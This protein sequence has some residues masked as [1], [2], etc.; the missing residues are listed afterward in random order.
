[1]KCQI[2]ISGKIKKNISKCRML[3]IL[4]R[5]YVSMIYALFVVLFDKY[6][7][8][9]FNFVALLREKGPS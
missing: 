6:V 8:C 4:P 3:K 2:L 1:M 9:L 7:V 5:V